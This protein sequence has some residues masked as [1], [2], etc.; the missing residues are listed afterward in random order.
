MKKLYFLILFASL[1]LHSNMSAV[2]RDDVHRYTDNVIDSWHSVTHKIKRAAL[3]VWHWNSI[4]DEQHYTEYLKLLEEI[5]DKEEEL[6]HVR[7]V[8]RS[9][10][11][12]VPNSIYVF[13]KASIDLLKAKRN[14]MRAESKVR[15]YKSRVSTVSE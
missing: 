7:E 6:A 3:K 15:A 4:I 9:S 14:R 1:S 5:Q 2:N 10:I 11:K 13:L 12:R 8:S